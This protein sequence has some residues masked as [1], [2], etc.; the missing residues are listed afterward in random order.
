M[1]LKD[2]RVRLNWLRLQRNVFWINFCAGN[3]HKV[4]RVYLHCNSIN[5]SFF[6]PVQPSMLLTLHQKSGPL[7]RLKK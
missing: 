6:I 2:I 4:M 1:C 5:R 3:K 7:Q